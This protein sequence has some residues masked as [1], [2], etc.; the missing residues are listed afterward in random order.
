MD[1]KV[2]NYR[3]FPI[4]TMYRKKELL[5]KDLEEIERELLSQKGTLH[6]LEKDKP[7]LEETDSENYLGSRAKVGIPYLLIKLYFCLNRAPI[8][9]AGFSESNVEHLVSIPTGWV[10]ISRKQG[11]H[12]KEQQYRKPSEVKWAAASNDRH[13][14]QLAWR[15]LKKNSDV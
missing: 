2:E 12:R 10:F 15:L 6:P 4:N 8:F 7:S 9:Q 13:P 1:L 14:Q 11:I 3:N 5:E